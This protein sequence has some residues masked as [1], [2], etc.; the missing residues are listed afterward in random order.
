MSE[1]PLLEVRDLRKSYRVGGREIEVLRG[2]DLALARGEMAALLGASGAGKST[3][4]HCLG[5]LD[6]PSAG[7]VR[8]RGVDAS[9]LSFAQRARTRNREI[10]F[11]FQFYHLIPELDAL[12]NT[13][14]PRWIG[15]GAGPRR[16]SW[17]ERDRA[18]ALLGRLGL[19]DRLLHRPAQLSGGE[20]QRVAI[21]RA[22][23]AEPEIVLCDEP[24]G[25]LDSRTGSEIVDL[26]LALNRE[27]GKTFVIATHNPELARR[28]PRRVRIE[29]GK[30]LDGARV[31]GDPGPGHAG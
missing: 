28:C 9:S 13:L 12:E 18:G 27:S 15:P 5:L 11:V 24:T 4:L 7:S 19:G 14:L 10:G 26:L 6:V 2:I 23:F 21:A 31:G 17:E 29:D 1:P 25:N 8:L 20:R 30:I 22:L 3:L 16:S